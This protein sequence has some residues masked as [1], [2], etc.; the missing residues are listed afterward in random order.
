MTGWATHFDVVPRFL[1][2]TL[3]RPQ[4]GTDNG[5]AVQTFTHHHRGTA[6]TDID[7][8]TIIGG[9]AWTVIILIKTIIATRDPK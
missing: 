6:M 4:N 5:S 1:K 8:I 2:I 3:D 9:T 7:I